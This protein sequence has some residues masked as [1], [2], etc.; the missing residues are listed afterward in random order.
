M[1]DNILKYEL[2]ED[3]KKYILT[4]SLIDNK[5]I[6]I[7]C[8]PSNHKFG[9]I[10]EF[11][12]N[13]LLKI[14]PIISNYKSIKEIQYEFE[15]C[16]LE[17]K[18][19]LLHNRTLF[20]ISFYIIDKSKTEKITLRLN[21]QG[22]N[23]KLNTKKKYNNNHNILNEIEQE[24]STISKEQTMLKEKI[25]EL[26]SSDFIFKTI[27]DSLLSNR[28]NNNNSNLNNINSITNINI[29]K[30]INNKSINNIVNN[31]Y[32]IKNNNNIIE[33]N[34]Y[35]F[36]NKKINNT[37]SKSSHKSG[38]SNIL[39]TSDEFIMLENKIK[40]YDISQKKIKFI[41]IYRASEDSDKAEIFHQK[42]NKFKNT[43]VFVETDKGKRFGGF[44]TQTWEDE[45]GINKKDEFAFIFSLDKLKIYDIIPGMN[46]ISC[47]QKYGPIFSE[48][49]ILIYDNAF[50]NGG[51]TNLAGKNYNTEKDYE[52]S[53]G[54]NKYGVKEIEVFYIFYE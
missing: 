39:K 29:N 41:L 3:K 25:E 1:E 20:D 26:L 31:N 21:Y 36:N 10:N 28:N 54:Y 38:V 44:T 2:E 13:D 49:Q 5:I 45:N 12:I 27:D 43:I 24:T 17:Q 4:T 46:A 40:Q 16:I 33:T 11:S 53:G 48:N 14:N 22:L 52:L 42:C 37:L 19:S 15:K 18:V 32:N 9:Y 23:M 47:H 30:N 8:Y 50:V 7:C 6:K 51:Q 34:N 35:K